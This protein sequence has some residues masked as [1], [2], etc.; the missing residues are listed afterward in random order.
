MND[1]EKTKRLVVDIEQELHDEIKIMAIKHN[2]TMK[3]WVLKAITK[4]MLLEKSY[5]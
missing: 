5:E 1:L 4:E 3:K 2:V